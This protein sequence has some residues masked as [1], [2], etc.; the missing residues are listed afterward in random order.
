MAPWLRLSAVQGGTAERC[1]WARSAG[2]P[3]ACSTREGCDG[4]DKRQEQHG[5]RVERRRRPDGAVAQAVGG[6][7][8]ANRIMRE[9]S[10]FIPTLGVRH[11]KR[12]QVCLSC[13]GGGG[14]RR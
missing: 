11:A 12:L 3:V 7:R 1:T 5:C 13:A 14:G 2:S 9:G 8:H 10:Q 4:G 6:A